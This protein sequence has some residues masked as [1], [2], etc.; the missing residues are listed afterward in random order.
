M[1]AQ[2]DELYSTDQEERICLWGHSMGGA[3]T[4]AAITRSSSK[5]REMM[6]KA[7]D[8]FKIVGN[9]GGGG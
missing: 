9:R 5:D 3:G 8:F 7:F 1:I 2:Y 6:A 4:Y